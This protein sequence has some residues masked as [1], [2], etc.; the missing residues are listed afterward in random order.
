MNDIVDESIEIQSV[1]GTSTATTNNIDVT[2]NLKTD[3]GDADSISLK[4]LN[5]STTTTTTLDNLT[6]G[7][8][9]SAANNLVETINLEI[10]TTDVSAVDGTTIRAL[11]GQYS[12]TLN[13]T[14]SGDASLNWVEL[15]D[16]T[17]TTT[18]V[19]NAGTYTG[20]LTLGM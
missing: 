15:R 12:G 16:P 1:D 2:V 14:G 7:R 18:S 19:I 5:P 3:T 4:T 10:G 17:G 13:I 6:I 8:A 9:A 20:N 11:D